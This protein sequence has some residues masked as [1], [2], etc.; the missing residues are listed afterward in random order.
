[1]RH[2]AKRL[3]TLSGK[4]F[5]E[6]NAIM[7]NLLTSFCLHKSLQT[8]QKKAKMLAPMIE[9]LINVVNT[10]DELNA[11]RAVMQLVYTEAASREL[12]T[13][14]APRFKERKSGM[15]R[16]TSIKYRAGDSAT[17]VKLELVDA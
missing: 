10:K 12:F 1:M 16:I 8:T 5:T 11:I 14:I 3:I 7:R 17:L 13:N 6:R 9:K 4:S 2:R 15:T